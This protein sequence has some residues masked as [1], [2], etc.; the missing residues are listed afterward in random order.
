MPVTELDRVVEKLSSIDNIVHNP[1]RLMILFALIQSSPIDYLRLMSLTSLSWGNISTHLSKLED[2]GYVNII[3]SFIGKKPHTSIK[4][5]TKGR[6]AYLKWGFTIV[7][8]VPEIAIRSLSTIEQLPIF[9]DTGRKS[10]AM[11]DF[12]N[13]AQVP[14][15]FFIPVYHTWS[16]ELPP[17]PQYN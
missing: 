14:E 12:L 1:A 7:S 13:Q 11:Y 16:F 17:F 9:P 10:A 6:N 8:A 3:K 5:T 2:A 4:L 15:R